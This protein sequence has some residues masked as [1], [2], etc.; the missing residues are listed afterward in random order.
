M[1]TQTTVQ[2]EQELEDLK[3]QLALKEKALEAQ[4]QAEMAEL[5]ARREQ[6]IRDAW[7]QLTQELVKAHLITAP[8]Y[9][10]IATERG[11]KMAETKFNKRSIEIAS[12]VLGLIAP[13]TTADTN[14]TTGRKNKKLSDDQ[15]TK[16][17]AWVNE[18]LTVAQMNK[19]LTTAPSPASYQRIN[20]FVKKIKSSAE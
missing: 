6:G 10:N 19:Q 7:D 1:E 9:E 3:L 13:T 14:T 5:K 16:I 2:I 11:Q 18:G 8:D 12:E 20:N 15:K 17:E 4:K